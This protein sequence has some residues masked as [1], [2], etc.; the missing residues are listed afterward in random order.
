MHWV[1]YNCQYPKCAKCD[2]RLKLYVYHYNSARKLCK[3]CEDEDEGA[4]REDEEDED[5]EGDEGKD[6]S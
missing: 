3:Q 5:E 2:E 1:C 4:C 6:S